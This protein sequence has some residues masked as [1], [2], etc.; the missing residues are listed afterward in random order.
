[1]SLVAASKASKSSIK[2]RA[3]SGSC[4]SV[5]TVTAAGAGDVGDAT[6]GISTGHASGEIIIDTATASAQE[7]WYSVVGT[8][9]DPDNSDPLAQRGDYTTA[10]GTLTFQDQERIS[11]ATVQIN[12]DYIYDYVDEKFNVTRSNIQQYN[13]LTLNMLGLGDIE[14]SQ[15][16]VTDNG[17]ASTFGFKH[18]YYEQRE[19]LYNRTV[20]VTCSWPWHGNITMDYT[21]GDV[22]VVD[23]FDYDQTAGN[24]TFLSSVQTQTIVDPINDDTVYEYADEQFNPTTLSNLWYHGIAARSLPMDSDSSTLGHIIDDG[25]GGTLSFKPISCTI[26]EGDGVDVTAT[27]TVTRIGHVSKNFTVEEYSQDSYNTT[28]CT[29]TA[30]DDY[31]ST[32]GTLTFGDRV[33]KRTFTMIVRDGHFFEYPNEF[34]CFATD[35]VKYEHTAS[36]VDKAIGMTGDAVTQIILDQ[37]A[38]YLSSVGD[39]AWLPYIQ[40]SDWNASLLIE[41]DGDAGT[42]LFSNEGFT[43]AETSLASRTYESNTNHLC[44]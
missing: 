4:V 29:S 38:A 19:E 14:S 35:N 44:V 41:D 2:L 27:L 1:M 9:I 3:S 20:T 6:C 7:L 42:L 11:T 43:V 13:S 10:S 15:M 39:L 18:T 33:V 21:T 30:E 34:V 8:P 37:D 32:T 22:D 23:S 16:T 31:Q 25:D 40:Q 17:D 5:A 26:V 36:G 28:D 24:L 12:D